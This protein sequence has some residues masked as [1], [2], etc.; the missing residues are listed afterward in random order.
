V[1]G[2]AIHRIYRWLCAAELVIDDA[3][4]PV[5]LPV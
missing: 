5:G 1:T 3:T 2:A 4:G